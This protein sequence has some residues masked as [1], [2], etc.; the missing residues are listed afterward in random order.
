MAKLIP[1]FNSC[2]PRMTSGEKRVAEALEHHLED[3]YLLWYDVPVG[4]RQLHPDFIILH[5]DRGLFILEVKDWKLDHIQRV[6]PTSVTLLT[7]DGVKEVKNPLLQARDYALA[8]CKMLERDA[9]LV[10]PVGSLHAGKLI[11]PYGYGVVFSNIS[12]KAF[13]ETDLGD[14]FLAH[15]VI[16]KDDLAE[17]QDTEAFQNRLWD[18]CAYQFGQRLTEDAIDRIRWHIFPEL[19]IV[20][21]QLSL[22]PQVSSPELDAMSEAISPIQIPPDLIQIMDLQQE[23][24]ARSLGEGH[25]VIHG[26]AGSGKTLI[27]AYRCQYL[28]QEPSKPI[29]VLCFNVALASRLRQI[30][31]AK[32]LTASVTVRNFHSWCSDLFRTYKLVMPNRD[33]Y[34][35]TAYFDE[36]VNLVI[37][38][39]DKGRIPKGQYGS[40]MLDEGHDFQPEWLKLAAQMVD[41]ETDSL[42][43]L[44]DDAQ[45][46]YSETGK[47]K[48]TF[49]SVGIKA[50]GRTTI[51]KI[52]YRNTSEVLTLAYEFAKEMMTPTEAQSEDVPV[53]VQPLS[54]GR[55]GPLPELVR[56]PS[57]KQETEYLSERV[58]QLHERGIAWNEM[59]IAYRYKFMGEEIYKV[60]QQAQVPVEWVN[61]NSASRSYQPDDKSIKLMTMHS[62]K[63]LEFPVVFIPGVGYLPNRHSTPLDEARLLYVAMTRATNALILTYD[64]NSDFVAKIQTALESVALRAS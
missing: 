27:L 9:A 63:G 11:F 41:P 7:P 39:V 31:Q 44:Y 43:V 30:I 12:R 3:N 8:V 4:H 50:Q 34:N 42:L 46:L 54:A 17:S 18:L 57:F 21:K 1:T 64:R 60:L 59:A 61:E 33:K 56:L 14:V 16:C 29:L 52:N 15:L 62:S 2:L 25:R 28:A 58:Q 23:Q 20:P 22:F 47:K 19:R 45:N 10:S 37:Q 36:L 40:V 35:G 55:H 24:L 5:P 26:V 32:N 53:L 6:T 48:F 51:L 49:K 13:L 38:A